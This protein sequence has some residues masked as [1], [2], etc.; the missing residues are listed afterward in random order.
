MSGE[1]LDLCYVEDTELDYN[2]SPTDESMSAR[3]TSG[4]SN[5]NKVFKALFGSLII[6]TS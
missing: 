5:N 1:V 4:G 2:A 3:G 6:R